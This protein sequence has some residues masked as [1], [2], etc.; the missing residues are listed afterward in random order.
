[1]P[2]DWENDNPRRARLGD[3]AE[4]PLHPL[5]LRTEHELN[6][7][8][9]RERR[10]FSVLLDMRGTRFQTEVW[11]TLLGLTKR[12]SGHERMGQKL[13]LVCLV[14]VFE[15]TQFWTL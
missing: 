15:C 8:F 11:D 1:M 10:T 4:A 9:Q 14:S 12:P 7:C 3:I 5:L 13:F 2:N 6:E